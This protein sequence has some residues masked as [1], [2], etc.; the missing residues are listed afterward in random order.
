MKTVDKKYL[1]R[2]DAITWALIFG[3][4]LVGTLGIASVSDAPAAGWMLIVVGFA[5]AA[6]GFG[7][8]YVRSTLKESDE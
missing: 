6:G 1:S 7:M 8:I 3:G 5:G 2:F 4:L